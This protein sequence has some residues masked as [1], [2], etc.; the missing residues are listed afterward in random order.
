MEK[1]NEPNAV[2]SKLESIA[3][4]SDY[5]KLLQEYP[6]ENCIFRGENAKFEKSLAASA[7]RSNK[8]TSFMRSVDEYYS[9][10]GYRLSNDERQNI[11]AFA[12]HHGLHTNLLDVTSNPLSA[13]FF[14]CHGYKENESGYVHIFQ[15]SD[16]I[17]ITD[18]IEIFPKENIFDLFMSGN[19]TV[20][21]KLCDLFSKKFENLRGLFRFTGDAFE[22]EGI[23]FAN[24]LFC[25]LF[26][27]TRDKYFE[28][29]K[30]AVNTIACEEMLNNI[31]GENNAI[32]AKELRPDFYGAVDANREHFKTLLETISE[33]EIMSKVDIA[34]ILKD[35][36][37]YY[38]IF[39]LYC[40]KVE[41]WKGNTDLSSY[42]ELF[43]A[44][45]YRPKIT[46]ERARLQQ[47]YFIYMPYRSAR[48][49]YT[50]IP[51]E[52]Q[53]ILPIQTVEVKNPA[54]ILSELDNI[55]VNSGTVYGDFDSIAKYIKEKR[56]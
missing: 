45:V 55:G 21:N 18:I 26:C 15:E 29:N 37:M 27:I 6:S 2:V 44:M 41:Y 30:I 56:R 53:N 49:M 46:F 11:I 1:L 5:I 12:Q 42:S 43:P 28:K 33:D 39:L 14:A 32:L 35:D 47:G 16:F 22:A 31:R 10:I 48:G 7:F 23:G 9:K 4:L 20:I 54:K 51:V 25:K 50:D 52:L 8:S 19:L 36:L 13:L 24:Q 17:D 3:D 38:V 34:Q 40:F